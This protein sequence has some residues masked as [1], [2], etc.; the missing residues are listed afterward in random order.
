MVRLSGF[1][2]EE[3]GACVPFGDLERD[4]NFLLPDLLTKLLKSRSRRYNRMLTNGNP[5]PGIVSQILGQ[6]LF[7]LD[8]WV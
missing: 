1:G 5:L 8:L 3:A 7:G 4:F 6:Q 2:L